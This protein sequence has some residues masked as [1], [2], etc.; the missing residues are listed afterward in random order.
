MHPFAIQCPEPASSSRPVLFLNGPGARG[1]SLL[2]LMLVILLM[3]LVAAVSYP[4]LSRGTASF[5][6]RATGRDVLSTL[7]YAREKAITEQRGMRVVV[8]R[9]TQQVVLSDDLGDGPRTYSVPQD[10]RISALQQPG[11]ETGQEILS[12]RFR[13]NGSSESGVIVLKSKTGAYLRVVT[14]PITGGAKIEA[15]HGEGPE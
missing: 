6:L 13:P 4:A 10:V 14:D 8:N 11:R 9:E 2:E 7:R 15:G 12:F 1:F 5:R 3:S